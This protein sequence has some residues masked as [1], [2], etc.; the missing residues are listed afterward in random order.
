MSDVGPE[1]EPEV[2]GAF[3]LPYDDVFDSEGE[4]IQAPLVVDP[5]EPDAISG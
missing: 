4:L 3:P 2:T 5:P 1:L